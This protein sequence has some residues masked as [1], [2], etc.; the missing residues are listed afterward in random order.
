[1]YQGARDVSLLEPQLLLPHEPSCALTI[2]IVRWLYL[3]LLLLLSLIVVVV[4]HRD[5]WTLKRLGG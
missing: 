5:C 1:M 4:T 2:I 3:L